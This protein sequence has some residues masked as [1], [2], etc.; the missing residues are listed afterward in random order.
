M[1]RG[2]QSFTLNPQA[3]SLNLA[4]VPGAQDS[5]SHTK[6]KQKRNLP[7][8]ERNFSV[9]CHRYSSIAAR[10]FRRKRKACVSFSRL[11][12]IDCEY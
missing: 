5:I 10:D 2:T 7:K 12:I 1:G 9:I 4:A 11:R 6:P 3:V 8:N